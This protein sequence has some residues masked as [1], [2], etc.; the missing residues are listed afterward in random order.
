MSDVLAESAPPGSHDEPRPPAERT[1][2][3]PTAAEV[4]EDAGAM[5]VLRA[6]LAATPELRQ[7]LLFTAVMALATALGKLAIPILIQQI[8]DRGVLG[9]AGFRPTFVYVSCTFVG[10]LVGF[11]YFASRWTYI[12][13]VRTAE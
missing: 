5:A 6:G 7:G 3:E 9:D 4:L 11:L 12:R 13:L 2:E 8:L 1:P 10:A